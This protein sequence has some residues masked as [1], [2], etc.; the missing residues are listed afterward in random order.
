[1]PGNQFSVLIFRDGS[2]DNKMRIWPPTLGC[3][4]PSLP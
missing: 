1:M 2:K 3:R 4:L